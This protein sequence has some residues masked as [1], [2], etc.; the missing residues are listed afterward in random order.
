MT[1]CTA[2]FNTCR[3]KTNGEFTFCCQIDSPCAGENLNSKNLVKL[4]QD[5]I[6]GKVID[7]CQKNCL[8]EEERWKHNEEWESQRQNL[9]KY[10]PLNHN[11][12]PYVNKDDLEYID[13]R[14]SN[15]C[16]FTCVMCGSPD[17]HL[18]GKLHGH[19]HPNI[20]WGDKEDEILDFIISCKNLKRISLAGGEPFY[21]KKILYKILNHLDRNVELKFITNVSVCDNEIINMM[22]EFNKGRL[23]CSIDGI[24]KWIEL[25]RLGSNWNVIEKN[26]LRF[27]NNLHDKWKVVLVPTFSIFNI[28]GTKDFLQWYF[29][30][31]Y[32]TRKN[33]QI[34]YTITTYPDGM[35]FYSLDQH[36]RNKIVNEIKESNIP[37]KEYGLDYLLDII[38]KDVEKNKK[39]I[40]A[41]YKHCD[42]IKEKLNIDYFREL[43]E[44]KN[45]RI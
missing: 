24:G 45:V 37:L 28:L 32:P 16:N 29:D 1:Y 35:T 40:N 17:S 22:N 10:F 39:E 14:V 36:V 4:R 19:E 44:L 26:I 30:K 15:I 9:G 13:V 43:P 3:I 8:D 42:F 12:A 2:P 27:C 5:V 7:H 25:Q 38:N 21:N 23:H 11:A 6:D 31:L 18:W 20:N 33:L 34:S 41:F